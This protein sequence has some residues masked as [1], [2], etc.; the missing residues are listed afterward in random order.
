M[1]RWKRR[2]IQRERKNMRIV[3]K[4][5]LPNP[6]VDAVTKDH[7]YTPN[8][9]SVTAILKGPCQT[10]LERRHDEEIEQDVSEMIWM[11]FGSSVH[12]IL[13]NSQE[14]IHQLKENKFTVD[15]PNGYKL[16]GIFDLYDDNTGTVTDYKTASVNKVLYKDWDDYRKQ[17]LIYCWMLRRIGFNAH[18]GEIVA[19]LKDH[20]TAKAKQ[21]GDYPQY[22]VY[23]ISWDFTEDDFSEIEE[24][25]ND[26]FA[27]IEYLEN[28]PDE[29][30][31]EC[32]EKERWHKDDTY[33]VMKGKNKR[34]VRVLQ[35]EGDAQAYI[36]NMMLD[37]KIH[38]IEKREGADNR[39]DNYC[40]V[41]KWCPFY[42]AKHACKDNE[43]IVEAVE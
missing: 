27:K 2:S 1:Y 8:Q 19:F 13:E 12:N 9:Y 31:P 5:N 16:S 39:C 22:P 40:N 29:L 37:T 7:K 14:T 17:T 24:F 10:I 23:R 28:V 4:F 6:I 20:S 15:M 38:R 18:R 42:K 34:A 36:D 30:L 25:I 35:T 26:R 41:N 43:H 3:N 33:A 32:G 21:G 11:L